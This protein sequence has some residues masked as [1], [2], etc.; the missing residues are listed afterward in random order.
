MEPTG[1]SEGVGMH[2]P[3]IQGTWLRTHAANRLW[4][5]GHQHAEVDAVS[6]PREPGLPSLRAE[7]IT[8]TAA[9]LI[10]IALSYLFPMGFAG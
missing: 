10:G 1:T 6:T 3:G 2:V 5:E 4:Q 7:C 9:L 8:Y